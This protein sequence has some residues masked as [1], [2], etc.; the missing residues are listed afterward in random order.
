MLPAGIT[1]SSAR[2][3]DQQRRE[4]SSRQPAEKGAGDDRIEW[5][6]PGIRR[7][8]EEKETVSTK[9]ARAQRI[10]EI[11][12]QIRTGTYNI[13][14]QAVAEAIIRGAILDEEA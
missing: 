13:R 2:N 3:A 1:E 11:R 12:E 6:V 7:A 8:Y 4:R 10:H 5:S 9:Q 14:A